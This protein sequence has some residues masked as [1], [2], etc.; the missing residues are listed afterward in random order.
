MIKVLFFAQVRELTGTAALDLAAEYAD[1]ATLRASFPAL[2]GPTAYFDG[3]G[4]TQTPT[5]VGEAI[6]LALFGVFWVVQT[7]ELWNDADPGLR[8]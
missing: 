1:V 7:V 6:A 8:E 4:G 2:A 5:V 3:P